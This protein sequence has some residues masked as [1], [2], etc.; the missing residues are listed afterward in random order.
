M[1]YVYTAKTFIL[2]IFLSRVH[3]YVLLMC[4]YVRKDKYKNA[5]VQLW[6]YSYVYQAW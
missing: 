2:I 3:L 4:A 5:H 1:M 6:E